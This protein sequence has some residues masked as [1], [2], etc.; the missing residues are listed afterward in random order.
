MSLKR[1]WSLY[2]TLLSEA[3][4]SFAVFD[5]DSLVGCAR[6]MDPGSLLVPSHCYPQGLSCGQVTYY[7]ALGHLHLVTSGVHLA[8]FSFSCED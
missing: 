8:P 4:Q 6:H 5:E 7:H 1:E 3:V 2:W